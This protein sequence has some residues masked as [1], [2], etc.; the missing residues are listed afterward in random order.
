MNSIVSVVLYYVLSIVLVA[1]ALSVDDAMFDGL[2]NIKNMAGVHSLSIDYNTPPSKQITRWLINF[3]MDSNDKSQIGFSCPDGSFVCGETSLVLESDKDKTI[4]TQLISFSEKDTTIERT[5]NGTWVTKSKGKWGDEID[6]TLELRIKCDESTSGDA[7]SWLNH[8]GNIFSKDTILGWKN[9]AFCY[10]DVPNNGGNKNDDEDNGL[11]WF[12]ILFIFALATFGAYL[13]LQAWYNTSS[14]GS[15]NDFLNELFD[16]V[17]ENFSRIPTFIGEILSRI[18]GGG[19][20][21]GGYSA[22]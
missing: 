5:G 8:D 17:V 12:T 22:V 6:S 20:N 7:I 16:V 2:P 1:S 14:M 13:V 21:R 3:K 10:T 15:T 19:S 11:G 9:S 4:I 18:T